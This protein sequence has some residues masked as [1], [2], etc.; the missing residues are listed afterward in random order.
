MDITNSL[1]GIFPTIMANVI[2]PYFITDLVVQINSSKPL[3]VLL[4]DYISLTCSS[5]SITSLQLSYSWEL[6]G[7]ILMGE[8][9]DTLVLPHV[10]QDRLGTYSCTASLSSVS[11][12]TAVTITSARK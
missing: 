3:A 4:G 7:T 12:S 9:S 8:T 2:T 6:N 11:A 10:S 5:T 1:M